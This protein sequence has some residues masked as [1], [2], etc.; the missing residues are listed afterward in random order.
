MSGPT[1][2]LVVLLLAFVGVMDSGCAK[3][4]PNL[5]PLQSTQ[6]T[7][8]Q[9]LNVAAHAGHGL[10]LSAETLQTQGILPVDKTR[11]LFK[12]VRE[13]DVAIQ[14]ATPL[15]TGTGDPKQVA[16]SVL[17]VIGS[18]PQLPDSVTALGAGTQ[19]QELLD[20]V[21][22]AQTFWNDIK[23]IT[24]AATAQKASQ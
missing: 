16:Q 3:R 20:L 22:L 5:T 23:A 1:K 21:S 11:D 15:S 6:L 14:K 12:W 24:A 8:S 4:V 18:I 13:A 17:D 19:R 2:Y 9:T 10:R 7:L